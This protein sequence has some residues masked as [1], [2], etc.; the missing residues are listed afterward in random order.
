MRIRIYQINM[1]RDTDNYAF[2]SYDSIQK[3]H[4]H[5]D[6]KSSLYDRV[7]D[8]TVDCRTLEDVYQKFNIDRP[9]EYTGR[10]LSKSDIV[11]VLESE[12]T[13]NG[14][15]YVDTV[16][17]K[18]VDFNPEETKTK[19][20]EKIKV[21]ILE[22]GKL[23]RVA[24]IERDIKSMQHAVKGDIQ[25]VYPFEDDVALICNEEGKLN[26]MTANRA[27]YMDGEMYDIV[28][29]PAFICGAPSNSSSFESLTDE[30]IKTYSEMFKKPERFYKIGDTITAVKYTPKDKDCR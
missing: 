24:E 19:A 15:Y 14:F 4:G 18:K 23:A 13:P 2:L 30:Q 8:N 12:T 20:S 16:G 21:V 26:R 3:F 22:P 25:A 7:Y 17:F 29:G 10:S 6:P 1:E 11:E 9:P 27:L 5:T 28:V